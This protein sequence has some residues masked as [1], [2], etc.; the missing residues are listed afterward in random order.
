[1]ITETQLSCRLNLLGQVIGDQNR[2]L[3]TD[4]SETHISNVA[5]PATNP[6][7][8]QKIDYVAAADEIT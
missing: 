8:V 5:V 1:M 7:L 2:Y 6:V 3:E 4:T